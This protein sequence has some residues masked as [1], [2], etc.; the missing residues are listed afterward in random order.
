MIY[1][2]KTEAEKFAYKYIQISNLIEIWNYIYYD[3]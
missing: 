3:N 2:T 1:K